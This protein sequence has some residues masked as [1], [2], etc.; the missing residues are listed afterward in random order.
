MDI[1]QIPTLL[2]IARSQTG[3]AKARAIAAEALA[4][5]GETWP[6][7]GC[8]ATLSALLRLAGIK[9]PMILGA[10]AIANRLGGPYDGRGWKHVPVGAQRPGDVGVTFDTGGNPGAD[11]VYLVIEVVDADEMIIVDN[12]APDLHSRWASG[13]GGKTRTDYFLRAT[14]DRPLTAAAAL[15][16]LANAFAPM[17]AASPDDAVAAIAA[18][19]PLIR[20]QWEGRGKA[21]RGY[22]KGMALAYARAHAAL[23]GTGGAAAC[24][25]A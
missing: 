13:K 8:A 15:G 5:V 4:K 11:H 24:A 10:G 12:Q 22:V 6:H 9:V 21:P 17:A 7:N 18:G 2:Q 14:A 25:R 23:K 1:D 20:L 16:L 3:R 19:S